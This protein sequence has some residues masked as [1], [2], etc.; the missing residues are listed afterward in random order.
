MTVRQR[1]KA[2]AISL[3]T[4]ITIT[5]FGI[6]L[7]G[8]GLLAGCDKGA[9]AASTGAPPAMK[10]AVVKAQQT[11]VPSP[12]SGSARSMATSMRRSSPRPTAI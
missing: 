9:S 2:G 10:V 7:V 11:D 6:L 4:A 5:S 1:H 12:A 8:A 3:N